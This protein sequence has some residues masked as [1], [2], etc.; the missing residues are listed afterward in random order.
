MHFRT[1][2]SHA[3][4]LVI[5]TAL[6][7]SMAKIIP[8]TSCWA[9]CHHPVAPSDGS[10]PSWP[11]LPMRLSSEGKGWKRDEK[12]KHV[13]TKCGIWIMHDNAPM[14]KVSPFTTL[15][16]CLLSAKQ[17]PSGHTKSPRTPGGQPHFSLQSAD[18]MGVQDFNI[19]ASFSISWVN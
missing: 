19:F 8:R 4:S 14:W 9:P 7:R 18:E 15:L 10:Q 11:L 16:M 5:P 13:T 2:T 1:N 6:L 17:H 3:F 12:G